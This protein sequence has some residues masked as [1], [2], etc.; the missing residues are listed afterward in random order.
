MGFQPCYSVGKDN[1]AG[2]AVLKGILS[3]RSFV[4]IDFSFCFHYY[5]S[6]V[7]LKSTVVLGK[8]E[9]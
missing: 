7:D 4:S 8:M 6:C 2:D 5:W 3:S 1:R 9:A